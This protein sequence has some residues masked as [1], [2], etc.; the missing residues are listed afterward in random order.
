MDITKFFDHKKRELG[1]Q[2]MAMII[3]DYAKKVI[4]APVS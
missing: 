2:W 3:K 4:T 1:S